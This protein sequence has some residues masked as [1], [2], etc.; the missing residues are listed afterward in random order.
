MQVKNKFGLELVLVGVV[1]CALACGGEETSDEEVTTAA[2]PFELGPHGIG[3]VTFEDETA[4]RY[5]SELDGVERTL[6]LVAWYPTDETRGESPLFQREDVFLDASLSEAQ[7]SYPVLVYSHGTKGFAEDS[8]ML[9]ERYA[10][11]GFI[12]VALDHMGDTT[13]NRDDQRPTEMYA[14][15]SL[16]ISAV[17]DWLVAP[18]A[19][20]LFSGRTDERFAL[21]GHSY[22][23]YTTFLSAGASFNDQAFEDCREGVSNAFCSSMT[24]EFETRMKEG[25]RDPRLLAV[26]PIAAGNSYEL[27]PQGVADIEIPTMMVTG[28]LDKNCSEERHGDPYWAALDGEEDV[29]VQLTTAGHHTFTLTCEFFAGLGQNDNGC[30]DANIDPELGQ[31][32]TAAYI[33][34]FAWKHLDGTS[35]YDSIL[36][37]ATS[38]DD[39]VV[40]SNK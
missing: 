2:D 37:G 7:E 16:D 25:F 40:V 20:H 22:G 15:R 30:T 35:A 28:G 3:Q 36:T 13:A 10:S 29:R 12:V 8:Y 34:A 23:G 11:H 26:M 17:I 19:S 24:P 1:L 18:S 27:G 32:L 5:I 21:T 33:L 38:L 14:W 9:M 31:N 39:T 6:R 4:L